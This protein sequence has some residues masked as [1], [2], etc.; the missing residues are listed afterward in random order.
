MTRYWS[1]TYHTPKH[2]VDLYQASLKDKGK[3]IET[4][5]IKNAMT[6]VKANNTSVEVT[7][8]APVEAKTSLDVFDF[9]K[10]P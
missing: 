9:F 5:A 6:N 7:L 2:F 4:H 3:R 1:R 10:D 8:L